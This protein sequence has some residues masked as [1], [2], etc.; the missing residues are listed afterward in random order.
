MTKVVIATKKPFHPD[1]VKHIRSLAEEA[2]FQVSVLEKYDGQNELAGAVKDAN[3]LIVRSDKVTEEIISSAPEL[4]IVVRA[5]AGYDNVDLEAASE[6]GVTVMNTPGQNSNA[7]AELTVGLMV[8]RARNMFKPFPGT[9]LM[10]KTLGIHGFGNVGRH[11]GRICRG[12]NMKVY[13]YDPFLDNDFISENGAT[14]V[15]NLEDLYKKCQYITV[16]IPCNEKTKKT[17]NNDLMSLMPSDAV[18]VNSARAGV[19]CE[20]SLKTIFSEREDFSYVTDVAPDI[21]EELEE[22][23]SDR[24]FATPK[25][26]GAQTKEANINAAVAAIRQIRAFIK[27]GDTTFKVN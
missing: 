22:K 26:M 17:I 9:E 20:D 6:K 4:K 23:Y 11:I 19:I 2:G 14:P 16:N 3:A 21:R 1:G 8:Y 25:K 13:A 24:F 15:N 10:D 18:L 5:G 12:F 7:V 27:E